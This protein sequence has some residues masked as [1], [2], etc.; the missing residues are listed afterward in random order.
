MKKQ[1]QKNLAKFAF[2][3]VLG[4]SI[5]LLA[6]CSKGGGEELQDGDMTEITVNLAGIEGEI[7]EELLLSSSVN[8]K[9]KSKQVPQ[10]DISA[11]TLPDFDAQVAQ[12]ADDDYAVNALQKGVTVRNTSGGKRM[13]AVPL[14]SRVRYRIVLYRANGMF[15]AS[16]QGIV[17]TQLRINVARGETYRWYAYSYNDTLAVADLADYNNPVVPTSSTRDLI[18]ATGTQNISASGN[19]PLNIVMLHRTNRVAVEIN[20]MGMFSTLTGV[21]VTLGGNYFTTGGNCNLLTGAVTGGTTATSP[22]YTVANLPNLPGTTAGDQKVAYYY[23]VSNNQIPTMR[24]TLSSLSVTPYGTSTA[25]NF[26]SSAAFQFNVTAFTSAGRSKKARIDLIESP[27]TL[28]TAR[29]ARSNLFLN[30]NSTTG[31]NPYRFYSTNAYQIDR[32]SYWPWRGLTPG[33]QAGTGDPCLR[34]Y[35]LGAWRTPLPTEYQ[36]ILSTAHTFST[37][38]GRPIIYTASTGTVSPYPSN[39][40][41]FYANG[42]GNTIA[43]INDVLNI[44]LDYNQQGTRAHLWADDQILNVVAGIGTFYYLGTNN[45]GGFLDPAAQNTQVVTAL[46]NNINVPLLGINILS[47]GYRNVRCVRNPAVPTTTVP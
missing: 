32:E 15:H 40:L 19:T 5:L 4:G 12:P 6:G 45:P 9:A 26:T 23:T 47:A 43:L 16:Q 31:H 29:W 17:G 36:S 25:R 44:G 14:A 28:G 42:F 3:T 1:L 20:T 21:T 46:L 11:Y 8:G 10:E 39:Q 24:V 33:G 13:V 38:A 34:V 7:S 2:I 18:T 35:P 37:A 22:V 30:G 41:V 27:L